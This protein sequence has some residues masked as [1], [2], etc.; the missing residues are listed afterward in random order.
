MSD[1]FKWIREHRRYKVFTACT[2]RREFWWIDFEIEPEFDIGDRV[3]CKLAQDKLEKSRIENS[4]ASKC[5]YR[6]ESKIWINCFL[7]YSSSWVS[8]WHRNWYWAKQYSANRWHRGLRICHGICNLSIERRLWTCHWQ[9]NHPLDWRIRV[10][11]GTCLAFKSCP[12]RDLGHRVRDPRTDQTIWKIQRNS[13]HVNYRWYAAQ[14]RERR[15]EIVHQ[16]NDK[17]WRKKISLSELLYF[18]RIK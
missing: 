12:Q 18:W 9:R 16:N 8:R 7:C 5:Q 10:H 6:I 11:L 13:F 4:R 1:A 14:V 17:I 3:P 15:W 2:I